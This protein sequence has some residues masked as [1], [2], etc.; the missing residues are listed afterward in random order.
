MNEW[1][2][3]PQGVELALMDSSASG[4]L[5]LSGSF[6]LQLLLASPT[7]MDKLFSSGAPLNKNEGQKDTLVSAT[8]QDM[9][10]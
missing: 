9:E 5:Y 3:L 6:P 8:V 4:D 2:S 10:Y 7:Q 1:E